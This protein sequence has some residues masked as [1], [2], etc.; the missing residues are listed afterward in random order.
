MLKKILK[1]Q[2]KLRNT[3]KFLKKI[4]KWRKNKKIR[5][6]Y[7]KKTLKTD[8]T[9]FNKKQKKNLKHDKIITENCFKNLKVKKLT[10]VLGSLW[11]ATVWTKPEFTTRKEYAIPLNRNYFYIIYI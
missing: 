2:T 7:K 4:L 11:S 8:W 3:T 6:N 1:N 10:C 5:S 9:K